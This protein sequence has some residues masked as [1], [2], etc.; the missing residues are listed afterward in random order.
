VATAAA[1]ADR[2]VRALQKFAKHPAKHFA[3]RRRNMSDLIPAPTSTAPASHQA[4]QGRSSFLEQQA[5]APA[6]S[7]PAAPRRPAVQPDAETEL[8]EAEETPEETAAE[9]RA[10]DL[11]A[12][13][14]L[15]EQAAERGHGTFHVV[16]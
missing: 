10:G 6:G 15:A 16:A 4:Q 2:S 8:Q 1:T 9:A 12:R 13:R 14:L 3:K 5:L 11:R 7:R